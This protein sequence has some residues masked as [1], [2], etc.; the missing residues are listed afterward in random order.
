MEATSEQRLALV[1]PELAAKVRAAA[2][3]LAAQGMSFRV[4]CGLR[5]CA[6]QDALYAQGRTRP[7]PVVTNARGGWS[8]HNFG[9]A[10]D[11]YPF[12]H[13][14]HGPIDL[15]DPGMPVFQ[16]MVRAL[17]AQGL[18]WGGDWISLKDAP[19]FQLAN[20]PETPN[21]ADRIA[22]ARGGLQAVWALY[23]PTP[24]PPVEEQA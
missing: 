23:T 5:T 2:V 15:S 18:A 22:F 19:H 10:V 17:K 4:A 14:D 16:A 24:T 13:D 6:E 20:V 1:H 7:G 9:C 12:I 8:N 21:S 3:Q 11:C